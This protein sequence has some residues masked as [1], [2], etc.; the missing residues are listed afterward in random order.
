M[1]TENININKNL[2]LSAQVINLMGGNNRKKVNKSK[3]R[4]PGPSSAN[5]GL[6][7]EG[8]LLSDWS[9]F[10]S[11]PSRGNKGNNG[12]NGNSKSGSR[13][14][15][16][17]GSNSDSK[18][19]PGSG[20]RSQSR[21]SKG[22][23]IGYV[24]PQVNASID[25]AENEESN[26]E[27]LNPVALMDSEKNPIVAYVD[28]GPVEESQNVEYI[29]D[30]TS[31][32]TPDESSHRGLGFYDEMETTPG[33]T[34]SSSKVE[35][36]E[37]GSSGEGEMDANVDFV[38]DA[39]AELG[40]DMLAEMS[41]PE[42]NSGYI[43]IGGTK[44]YTQDITDEDEEE[45]LSDEESSESSGSEDCSATS[46][47]DGSSSSCSDIDDEVA[48]DYFEGIGGVSNIINVDQ[49]VKG[50]PYL[51][52]DDGEPGNSLNETVKKLSGISLQEASR[53][54]GIKI[55]GSGRKFRTEKIQNSK[56]G[57]YA[58]SSALDDLMLVKDPRTVSGRKKHVARLPQSWPSEPRK[59]KKFR[60]IPGEKKKHRKE[61]IAAKRRD[62]MIRRGV[63]L[64]KINLKLQQ[65]VL[66][67]VDMFTFQPMHS[68]DCSQVRRLAAIYRLRS[69][70][71]GSGKKGFVTVTRTQHTCMPSSSDKI[72]LEK[73]IG[74]NDEDA[75]FSVNGKPAKVDTNSARKAVRVGSYTSIGSRS[76]KDKSNQN[77]AN[78]LTSKE[79]KKNKRSGK[80]GS[81]AAQPLSF[82]SSGI[83]NAEI[84]E[85]E[86]I[87][88][89]ETKGETS[90]ES[91]TV[92]NSV[93]YRAFEMHTT[94]FGSKMMA[95]M[96]YVEGGGL[97]KDGQGMAQPIEV[98][99]RPKSLG[100]GAE[101]SETKSTNIQFQP[102]VKSIGR[103]NGKSTKKE[104][105]KIG[106][107]EKHTKGFGS[108]MMAKMG[109][110]EG[111]GLGRDSQGMV[112]PLVAVRRPKARGL[113]ATS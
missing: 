2:Y 63:D 43:I 111:S 32:F 102:Q 13:S 74:A 82:V 12:G 71:Q 28:E 21:M 11:P 96:G 20:V 95:K 46:E 84:V 69:G 61:M 54:Y 100:L 7:V 8:G 70:C 38:H 76:S 16:G 101:V 30:Y 108:K 36:K 58:W 78:N 3:S 35:E 97:G 73:L 67:G 104:V 62:R 77:S 81:Y 90:G 65:M 91:K 87:E 45:E 15:N 109:F 41:F 31:S 4:R 105:H 72:R 29:Y 83:L 107:F 47:S 50:I 53:E 75:D 34:G 89:N 57:N 24:Y 49:L 1:N 55:P 113:G 59:S 14:G 56:S 42:E 52:D 18:S 68:R 64:Q 93:E 86:T 19:G 10:N 80:V 40:E 22:N 85:L 79:S 44:I 51:S 9:P 17:K 33:G 88:S 99:Q 66:D 6:F 5:R 112:N 103:A 23:A 25:G 94:G 98:S 27:I 92:L 37:S 39:N 110:V 48:A 60:A 106:S 26:L